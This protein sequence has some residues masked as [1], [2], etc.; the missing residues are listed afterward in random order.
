MLPEGGEAISQ[1]MPLPEGASLVAMHETAFVADQ[2]S[3]V[4]PFTPREAGSAV[5][6]RTGAAVAVMA[7]MGV[8]PAEDT[9]KAL[10]VPVKKSAATHTVIALPKTI[11][12]NDSRLTPPSYHFLPTVSCG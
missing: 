9:A 12:E 3:V 1:A 7:T 10:F 5:K 6:V 11:F 8:V 4:S 2:T